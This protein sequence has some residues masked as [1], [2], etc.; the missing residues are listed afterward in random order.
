MYC[1][2]QKVSAHA[3]IELKK[4]QENVVDDTAVSEIYDYNIQK[5]MR[6][7]MRYRYTQHYV[8]LSLCIVAFLH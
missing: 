4:I 3:C 7:S 6:K 1:K 8:F 2:L 5:Y